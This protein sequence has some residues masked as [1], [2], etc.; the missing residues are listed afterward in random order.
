MRGNQRIV[1]GQEDGVYESVGGENE[2]EQHAAEE[3]RPQV[4]HPHDDEA[5]DRADDHGGAEHQ[6]RDVEMRVA[7]AIELPVTGP[8][9][10]QIVE[11][12]CQQL[13]V[14]SRE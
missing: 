6:P 10:N 3:Q 5:E 13:P 4:V 1:G 7:R 9:D 14:E 12:Y 11:G 8:I 2:R